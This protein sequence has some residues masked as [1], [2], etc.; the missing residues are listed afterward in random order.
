MNVLY[1]P[2]G[3]IYSQKEYERNICQAIT[4]IHF[5]YERIICQAITVIMSFIFI[6][7][8]AMAKETITMNS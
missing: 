8:I 2:N 1:Q 6:K 4:I 5:E 7:D 3:L